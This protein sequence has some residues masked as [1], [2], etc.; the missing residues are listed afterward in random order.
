MAQQWR[1]GVI[2]AAETPGGCWALFT[3]AAVERF[4]DLE[5][6]RPVEL[7]WESGEQD[8]FAF[9]ATRVWPVGQEPVDRFDETFQPDAYSS[10]LTIAVED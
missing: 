10:D 1:P 8:G 3:A 5:P 2:D 9:R 7:E 4:A 6:G